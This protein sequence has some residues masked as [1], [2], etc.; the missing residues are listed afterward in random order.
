MFM[1]PLLAERGWSPVPGELCSL[2]C[3]RDGLLKH[4]HHSEIILCEP[5]ALCLESGR[6]NS[7]YAGAP[8]PPDS[9]ATEWPW[10]RRPAQLV[11]VLV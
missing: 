3:S 9:A 6:V 10:V 8:L 7:T 4:W 1:N 11:S 2:D 5:H